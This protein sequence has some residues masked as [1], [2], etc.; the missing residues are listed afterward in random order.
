MKP[1]KLNTLTTLNFYYVSEIIMIKY[2]GLMNTLSCFKPT[3][4][5][6]YM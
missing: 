5:E 3:A 4:E 2:F 1:N 6:Y